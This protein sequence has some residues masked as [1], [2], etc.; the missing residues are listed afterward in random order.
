MVSYHH[1]FPFYWL[2]LSIITKT[3]VHFT[4]AYSICS[5]QSHVRI[6]SLVAPTP[7]A[8]TPS[9]YPSLFPTFRTSDFY[10][11]DICSLIMTLGWDLVW[12]PVDTQKPFLM[13]NS[14]EAAAVH[15]KSTVFS[16][17]RLLLPLSLSLHSY[18]LCT[19]SLLLEH[20]FGA[21]HSLFQTNS[22]SLS[23]G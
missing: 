9:P 12:P 14:A 10:V 20:W 6:H 1:T 3:H 7:I 8:T 16:R 23:V 11:H 5:L 17:G 15:S 19:P 2:I 4:Y 21:L 22:P 18:P 13:Q